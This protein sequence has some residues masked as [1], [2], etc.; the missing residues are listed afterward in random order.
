VTAEETIFALSTARGRAAIAV[1]R[2]SGPAAGQ[3]LT[4]LAGPLPAPR[5]AAL[6][7]LRADD[8][9]IDQALVLWFPGPASETGEDLAEFQVHGGPA[10]V[11][12]VLD[13]LAQIPGCRLA[14][15]GE[16]TRR[17]FLAGKLDLT[18]VEGLADLIAAE[19]AVQRRQAMAQMDGQTARSVADWAARSLRSLAYAEAAIDFADEEL[20]GDLMAGVQE[21]AREIALEIG[22]TLA[23]GR[24]GERIRDGLSIALIGP[25]N[26]G[27]SSLLNCLAGREAAIVSSQAGTTRDVIEVHLD[28]AGYPVILADTA[29]LR[30]AQDPIEAEGIRRAQARAGAAD[31]KI[32]VLDS[33][34]VS[35]ETWP[36]HD[37]L[38]WNKC[39]L[40]P[41][42]DNGGIAVSARTGTG[43]DDL[44]TA[45]A[46]RAADLLGGPAPIVT[47]AR[48]REALVTAAA[49]FDRAANGTEP[50]LIAED[51]RSAVRSLGRITGRV[52][53]E[54]LLDVIFRD[55]CIGK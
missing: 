39:D 12:G 2:V 26:T 43:I 54:D 19:T 3:A 21:V 44:L 15:P 50:A 28:L 45:C 27:K 49:A 53:V 22:S 10:V 35:R 30:E 5:R 46:A 29:G 6:R 36:A 4:M 32:L 55:F 9:V 20:P 16:F 48:H 41:A 42:P 1:I 23:D 11:G 8:E 17:A 38:V 52:D 18:G 40:A 37:L 34:D 25:P 47:R 33:A 31:L 14:E 7:S 24:R 13:G 51:L